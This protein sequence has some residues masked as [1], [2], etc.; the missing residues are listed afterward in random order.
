MSRTSAATKKRVSRTR[1]GRTPGDSIAYHDGRL[2]GFPRATCELQGYAYDAKLRGARL[3]R[4]VWKD[5]VLAE[6][7]EQQAADLK[8]RFNRDFWVADG[9]FFALAL[10]NGESRSTRCPRT[11]AICCGA[12]SS[13]SRRRRPS[14]AT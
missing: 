14:S 5:P 7:L 2:P 9:E 3:A 1:A 12:G 8:R 11:T 6:A 4:L 10:D 13:T